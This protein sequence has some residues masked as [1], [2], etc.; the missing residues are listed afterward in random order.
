MSYAVSVTSNVLSKSGEWKPALVNASAKTGISVYKIDGNRSDSVQSAISKRSNN[1]SQ[2]YY[3][4]A[5]GRKP[6]IYLSWDECK[7]QVVKFSNPIF[8]KFASLDDAQSF[9]NTNGFSYTLSKSNSSQQSHSSDFL[10]NLFKKRKHEYDSHLQQKLLKTTSDLNKKHAIVYTDGACCQNGQRGAR[11]GIGVFWGVDDSRNIS[12]KLSGRPTNNRAEIHA[13]IRAIRQ[14]KELN[15]ESITIR[16]DSSFLINSVTVWMK[17]WLK[18]GWK[19]AN[20]SAVI[21]KED[22]EELLSEMEGIEVKWEKVLAHSGIEGNEAAD[23]LAVKGAT[24]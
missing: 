18:N 7:Q 19:V 9:I 1:K 3:A 12:E 5:R 2:F 17:K 16:T 15:Y 8:K 20:G 23:R 4:V 13:A 24:R 21:N 11:A 14:A 6:G 10:G 22:F